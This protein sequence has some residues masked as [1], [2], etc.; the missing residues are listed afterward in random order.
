[1]KWFDLAVWC[2]YDRSAGRLRAVPVQ[3]GPEAPA[4][5]RPLNGGLWRKIDGSKDLDVWRTNRIGVL[6]ISE[7]FRVA[8]PAVCRFLNLEAVGAGVDDPDPGASRRGDASVF[9]VA[10][11]DRVRLQ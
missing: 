6:E 2:C 3:A 1:M 9:D 7:G 5:G 10:V 11:R 8:C 4:A